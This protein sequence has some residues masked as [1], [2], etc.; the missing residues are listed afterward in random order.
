MHSSNPAPRPPEAKPRWRPPPLIRG[1]VVLHAGAIGLALVRPHLWPWALSAVVADHLLITAAGL[2]PRSA[3][4]G[5]NWTR[6][7]VR[8]AA[9][10]A[11]AIT[12]DDGPDAEVTPRVLDLLDEHHAQATFFCI[13]ARIVRHGAIARDIIRRGHEIGNHSY[14]HLKR[15]SLLGPRAIADEVMRAQLAIAAA[16]G[17][18]ARFFRAP[19]GFRNPFL[20]PVLAHAELELVSWT[21]RG[22]DTVN[23]GP[24]SVFGRLTRNLAARD[25]LLLHDGNAARTRAGAPIILEVLPR[26]LVALK[27]AGLSC[28]TLSRALPGARQVRAVCSPGAPV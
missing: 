21:R 3:L 14:R 26:L 11:V 18:T 27:A 22:F 20:E 25:I 2:T 9:M 10:P 17:E 16:A 23:D 5:P 15:F 6:L 28:V 8:P 4:L 19:A 24:D 12:I 7:P 13:G 1:S